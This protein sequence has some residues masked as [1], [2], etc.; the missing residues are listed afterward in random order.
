MSNRVVPTGIS[1]LDHLLLGGL[2]ADRL[3]LVQGD[4]GVGKTTLALQFLLDGVSRGDKGMYVTFSE[5]KGEVESVA[6]SHG[7]SLNGIEVF[8]FGEL[9]SA[10]AGERAGTVF[11]PAETELAAVTGRLWR[12]FERAA[13]SRLVF[14]SIA[15]LRLLSGDSLRY[16]RQ[17]LDLKARTS[18]RRCTTLLLDDRT[19]TERDLQLQSLAHGVFSLQ[20]IAAD[21]GS[22]KRRLEIVKF[23]GLAFRDG[24]HD[25]T[26][27][28]GGLVVY[29]RL[30]AAE[31]AQVERGTLKSGIAPLDALVG[32]GLDRGS[33]T[34]L[35]GPAGAGKSTVA[36]RFVL[37]AAEQGE[38]SV[39]YNF[40][41]SLSMLRSRSA[42]LGMDLSP[43]ERAERIVLK[44][45]NSA[46][47]TPG[48][49]AADIRRRVEDDGAKV[50]V[51]D[52]LNGYLNAMP[53]ER[54]LVLHLHELL[55]YAAARGVVMLFVTSQL[56]IMGVQPQQPVDA[57]YLADAVILF[58]YYEF[59]GTVRQ[60][61]SVFKRRGGS[62]ERTI[63]E[64][65]L[66]PPNGIEVGAPLRDFRGVLAGTPVYLGDGSEKEP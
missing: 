1:G 32:G 33:G 6:A 39:V 52:S 31:H 60:A 42:G 11:H 50:V 66:G 15:E 34:L 22:A 9:Q 5:T 58:R 24:L 59:R 8:E 63:R 38:R 14:D 29:P 23:R 44:S 4:P 16:R 26:I 10:L 51:L 55:A 62:H 27:R 36:L 40:D 19:A 56:G 54:H 3:Y 48:Q 37:S 45:V 57:S 65:T 35:L 43:H 2:Q 20:R 30:V 49:F 25:F 28:T 12:M 13:P 47:L 41:E 64:L 21:Y 7:W 46:E 18:A 17:L 53:G 61:I